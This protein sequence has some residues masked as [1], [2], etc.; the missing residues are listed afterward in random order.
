MNKKDQ[1]QRPGP[2]VTPPDL[3][4]LDKIRDILF[5]QQSRRYDRRFAGLEK[6]LTE[7]NEKLRLDLYKRLD[8]LDARMQKGI[9]ELKQAVKKEEKER[10]AS[11]ENA[12]ANLDARS[13]DFDRKLDALGKDLSDTAQSIDADLGKRTLELSEAMGQQH[14]A[15]KKLLKKTEAELRDEKVDRKALASFF[16]EFAK[17]LNDG[18]A[19]K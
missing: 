9:K 13:G 11:F 14:D 19:P 6:S 16:T 18:S 7:S 5:G 17:R 1:A 8:E 4:N 3:A 12:T 15:W 10:N 2:D